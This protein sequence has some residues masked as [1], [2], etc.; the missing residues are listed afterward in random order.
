MERVDHYDIE[1]VDLISFS[2][3]GDNRGSFSNLAPLGDL[4]KTFGNGSSLAVSK[5]PKAGTL[6]GL[7]FQLYPYAQM[8]FVTCIAGSVF[9]VIVDLRPHSR[10]YGKW[11]G[12][13]LTLEDCLSLVIPPGLAHGFQTIVP[14]T[15]LLYGISAQHSVEK[16]R[17]LSYRELENEWPLAISEISSNDADG[18]R[19]SQ[20]LNLFDERLK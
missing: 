4:F 15:I 13:V 11:A 1:G 14:E 6:R 19:L 5:N 16:S 2:Y 9:D 12:R 7:H 18:L 3:K 10:T 20:C 8:K 17:T